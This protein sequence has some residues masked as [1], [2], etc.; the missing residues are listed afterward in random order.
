MDSIIDLITNTDESILYLMQEYGQMIYIILFLIIFSE[1]G[2]VI[3]PFLP[4]DALL[5]SVGVISASTDLDV[6]ILV[7]SLIVAAILGNLSNY[8][9]GKYVGHRFMQFENKRFQSYLQQTQEFYDKHGGKA[10]AYS[11]FFPIFRTYVPFVAGV[12]RMNFGAFNL[13]NVVGGAVWVLIFVLGGFLLGDQP[14][15]KDNFAFFFTLLLALTLVP[16]IYGA[17]KKWQSSRKK[18][19]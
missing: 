17:Y 8:F 3:F 15:F 1:T 16:F 11:R 19:K 9:I 18:S 2:L 5:L 4:G 10:V 13:Y 6:K 7:P 14:W 12:T